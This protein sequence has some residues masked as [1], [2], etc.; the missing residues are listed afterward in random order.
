MRDAEAA[1]DVVREPVAK[2]E[3]VEGGGVAPEHDHSED[4][5]V[6]SVRTRDGAEE[7]KPTL[8]VPA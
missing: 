5:W 1:H 6:R 8:R 7:W 4:Q 2:E 3:A